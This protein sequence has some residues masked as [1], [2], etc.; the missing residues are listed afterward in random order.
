MEI[1]SR[2]LHEIYLLMRAWKLPGLWQCKVLREC[3]VTVRIWSRIDLITTPCRFA[4]AEW[5]SVDVTAKRPANIGWNSVGRGSAYWISR[6][7]NVP[8]RRLSGK[9]FV[10]R[11]LPTYAANSRPSPNKEANWPVSHV[12]LRIYTKYTSGILIKYSGIGFIRSSAWINPER[13]IRAWKSPLKC[14]LYFS[15]AVLTFYSFKDDFWRRNLC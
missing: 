12:P 7:S 5:W 3:K 8:H 13:L 1:F 9:T 10:T 2:V 14:S 15:F 6:G 11:K 4:G